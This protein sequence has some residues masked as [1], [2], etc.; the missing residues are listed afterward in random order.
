M[1]ISTFTQLSTSV[2]NWLHRADLTAVVEDF[3]MAGEWKINRLLRIRAMEA[4]LSVAIASGVAALPSDYVQLKFA[5]IS[6]TPTQPLQRK[7]AQWIGENYPTRSSSGKPLYI[8]RQGSNFVFG[9]YPDSSYTV[10]GVYYKRLDPLSGANETNW[11]TAKP[12]G[13]FRVKRIG[14]NW[15]A[16]PWWRRAR[17]SGLRHRHRLAVYCGHG[18]VRYRLVDGRLNARTR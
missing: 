14:K 5:Y 7:T 10:A 4:D 15:L 6:G 13:R 18:L 1:T 11:F 8:G 12:W 16:V 3:I 9:P 17:E 2:S